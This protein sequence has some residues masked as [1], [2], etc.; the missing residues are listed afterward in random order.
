MTRSGLSVI[1]RRKNSEDL[2]LVRRVLESGL[3]TWSDYDAEYLARFGEWEDIKLLSAMVEKPDYTSS[4]ILGFSDDGR[5]G[6]AARAIYKLSKSRLRE[7]LAMPL[8]GRLMERLIVEIPDK[9][10]RG[11]DYN[12]LKPLFFSNSPSVRKV[13]V[14]KAIKSSSS[15]R[16]KE[17]LSNYMNE[18]RRYYNI[19][20]WLD[21]G[22]NVPRDR[23][24]PAASREM[25]RMAG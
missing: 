17:L 11:L 20:H 23:A 2:G 14:L 6:A 15:R 21:F 7:L 13:G 12:S 5:Y 4:T 16:I 25:A 8:Q 24:A 1:E 22:A 9:E 19:I 3:V 10:F 18:D